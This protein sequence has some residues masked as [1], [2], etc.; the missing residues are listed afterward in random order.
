MKVVRKTAWHRIG[1]VAATTVMGTIADTLLAPRLPILKP[2][3]H[4][5]WHPS[6]DLA[7]I[8]FSIAMTLSVNWGTLVGFAGGYLLSRRSK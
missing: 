6:V 2:H 7:V 8:Q 4:V 1:L 3:T 5:S